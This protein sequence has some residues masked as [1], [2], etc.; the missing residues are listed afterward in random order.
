MIHGLKGLRGVDYMGL[1]QE[2][3]LD[4]W[5]FGWWESTT[6]DDMTGY[7]VKDITWDAL[8]LLRRCPLSPS[9]PSASQAPALD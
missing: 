5:G 2:H 1:I 8:E 9:S 4:R 7:S 3:K 6:Q